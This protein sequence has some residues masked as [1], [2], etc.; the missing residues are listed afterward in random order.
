MDSLLLALVLILLVA[1]VVAA[2]VGGYGW[3]QMRV[4][5]LSQKKNN[6]IPRLLHQTTHLPVPQKVRDN[7]RKYA[8]G[9]AHKIYNDDEC[10]AFLR[11]HHPSYVQ[12]WDGLKEGA[13][14]ADLFRYAILYQHGGVYMDIKMELLQPLDTIVDHDSFTLST[15]L[16][17]CQPSCMFQ[18]FIAAPPRQRLFLTLMDHIRDH[19]SKDTDYF[20]F[21][22]DMYEKI[23]DD[24]EGG[25]HGEGVY[26]SK[27]NPQLRYC[28]FQE[29]SSPILDCYDGIDKA[30]GCYFTEW[31]GKRILKNRYAD[32]PWK[33]P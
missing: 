13:H 7:I 16:C 18:A 30:N 29:I 26:S 17:C 32:Y 4:L 22:K 15:V 31:K 20:E 11:R 19:Q 24:V 8:P 6:T 23:H 33:T 9:Y 1:A 28:L 25:L 12:T 27:K 10:R 14:K 2:A 5:A 3:R 21:V